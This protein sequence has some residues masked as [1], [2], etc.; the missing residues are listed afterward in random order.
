MK[1]TKHI[2]WDALCKNTAYFRIK[3]DYGAYLPSVPTMYSPNGSQVYLRS[4]DI[5]INIDDTATLQ[6]IFALIY[7]EMR[8]KIENLDWS[9]RKIAE[10]EN[11]YITVWH[12]LNNLEALPEW[13]QFPEF[14]LRELW[15]RFQI[16][17]K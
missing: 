17:R 13:Y 8:M 2:D 4:Q 10:Y 9:A 16:N 15:T 14:H 7:D 1:E 12:L 3:H 5:A 6:N 11:D